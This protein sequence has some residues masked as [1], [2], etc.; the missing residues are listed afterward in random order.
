MEYEYP[1]ADR[2]KMKRIKQHVSHTYF[3]H[4]T[5]Y[6]GQSLYAFYTDNHEKN[7]RFGSCLI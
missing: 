7:A 1:K 5:F 4:T 3:D 6:E 2:S